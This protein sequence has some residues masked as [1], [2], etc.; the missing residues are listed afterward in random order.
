MPNNR[1]EFPAKARRII[2]ERA[3]YRC[4][5]PDCRR[6]TLG[7]GAGPWDVACIGVAAHIYSAS[8]GG[9]RGTGGWPAA[10]RRDAAN[11]IWLCQDHARMIDTNSGGAFPASLLFQWR[12]VHEAY[13]RLEMRGLA[14]PAAGLITEIAVRGGPGETRNR[15]V[16]LSILNFVRGTNNSG[17]STLL[18]LLACAEQPGYLADRHWINGLRADVHWFDPHPRTLRLEAPSGEM[19]LVLDNRSTPVVSAPYRTIV[20]RHHQVPLRN[21][22]DLASELG[23]SDCVFLDVLAQVPDRVRGMVESVE[24]LNGTPVVDLVGWPE[25][26]RC[27]GSASGGAMWI[28]LFES[29][30]ALAQ[31]RSDR[32]PTLLLVDE[33]ELFLHPRLVPRMFQLLAERTSGFQT[34]VASHAILPAELEREWSVIEITPCQDDPTHPLALPVMPIPG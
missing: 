19:R 32:E 21:H 13:L 5:K 2:A 22:H 10:R 23:L 33:V 30:I 29:A 16:P 15:S 14:P 28:L 24:V 7:P 17:K 31:I 26:I 27:D 20:V 4:S 3:G 18:D 9:P 12:T 1:A 6:Q 34:V 8:P 25:P 11:G